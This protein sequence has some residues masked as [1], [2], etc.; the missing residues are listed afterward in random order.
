MSLDTG[1]KPGT[2]LTKPFVLTGAKLLVN[3]NVA[4]GGALEVEGL[5]AAG[6]ISAIAKPVL[7]DQLR[8]TVQWKWGDLADLKGK[9]IDLRFKLRNASLYSFW[10]GES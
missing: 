4:D 8:A 10:V 5:D 7:G 1:E 9:T 2:L 3:A 6:D